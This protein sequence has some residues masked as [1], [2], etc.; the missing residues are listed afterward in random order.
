MLTFVINKI[1]RI[2]RNSEKNSKYFKSLDPKYAH[3]NTIPMKLEEVK[4]QNLL[5]ITNK[6]LTESKWLK[7]NNEVPESIRVQV[8]GKNVF[9]MFKLRD[10]TEMVYI[11]Y[12]VTDDLYSISHKEKYYCNLFPCFLSDS[13]KKVGVSYYN[14]SAPFSPQKNNSQTLQ[15]NYI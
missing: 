4:N 10:S 2:L 7:I 15:L 8:V 11:E 6:F 13:L 12:N 3:L 1:S 5:N 9:F 14:P